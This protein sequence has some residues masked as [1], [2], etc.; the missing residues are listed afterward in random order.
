MPIETAADRLEFFEL[1]IDNGHAVDCSLSGPDDFTATI[2]VIMNAVTNPVS[3]YETD[4]EAAAPNFI[5][6]VED[7]AGVVRRQVKQYTAIIEGVTYQLQRV[8]DD[9]DGKIPTV[10]L[11]K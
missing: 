7:L 2:P 5:C 3:L 11:K 10:Y 1:E 8:A 9:Q 6:R 4:V